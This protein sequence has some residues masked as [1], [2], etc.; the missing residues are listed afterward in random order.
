[1]RTAPPTAR[2]RAGCRPAAHRTPP[3]AGPPPDRR[4]PRG[5]SRGRRPV[6]CRSGQHDREP[7]APPRRSRIS[8]LP[9][10]AWTCWATMASPSP[11]PSLPPRHS[12][13]GP[14]R[15]GRTRGC[16]RRRGRRAPRRR[17]PAPAVGADVQPDAH[18][19]PAVL[20]GVVHEVDDQLLVAARVDVQQRGRA[21]GLHDVDG[22]APGRGSGAGERHDV[23]GAAL[24]RPVGP[25]QLQQVGDELLEARHLCGEQVH[26]GA[27]T[28]VELRAPAVEDRRGR[29]QRLQR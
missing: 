1:M 6:A 14:G 20:G 22:Q 7:R 11:V 21:G 24:G 25:R 15:S 13:H 27:R 12:R 19:A 10:C 4:P 26:G 8:T 17:P 16:A 23:G 28:A 18:R 5:P 9:R 29:R 3:A 2:A